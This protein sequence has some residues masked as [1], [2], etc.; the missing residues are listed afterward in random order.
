[1]WDGTCQGKLFDTLETV[2]QLMRRTTT[3]TGL[4]ATVNVIRR[5][6][7]IG[8]QAVIPG[9]QTKGHRI[10]PKPTLFG[11]VPTPCMV[12]GQESSS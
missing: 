8:R 5:T 1:M 7:D 6:Y 2:V 9:D 10:V 3:R 11:I 4:K 12:S